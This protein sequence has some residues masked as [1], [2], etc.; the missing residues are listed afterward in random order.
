MC[1]SKRFGFPEFVFNTL[2]FR[3]VPEADSVPVSD[4][5]LERTSWCRVMSHSPEISRKFPG[6]VWDIYKMFPGFF[7][8]ISGKFPVNFREMSGTFIGFFQDFSGTFPGHFRKI[9]G[10]SLGHV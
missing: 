8:D 10:K 1:G 9:S 4:F 3:K 2:R 7:R 5:R 6:N